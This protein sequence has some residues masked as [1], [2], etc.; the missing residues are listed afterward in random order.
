MRVLAA[1]GTLEC[2]EC[3]S[4]ICR[5]INGGADRVNDVGVLR[6]HPD[7][8][9]VRALAVGYPRIVASHVLPRRAL[10]VRPI[11][12]R[13]ALK[14]TANDVNTLTLRMHRDRNADASRVRRQGVNL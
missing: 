6:V 10:I 9:A 11:Q 1:G 7:A 4:S 8:G 5:S 12:T 13:A 14:R 3:L 2:A